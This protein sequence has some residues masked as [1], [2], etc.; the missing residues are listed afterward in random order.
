QQAFRAAF[1][2]ATGQ[3]YHPYGLALTAKECTTITAWWDEA[4]RTALARFQAR[5]EVEALDQMMACLPAWADR[6]YARWSRQGW[7]EPSA[8]EVMALVT[9]YLRVCDVCLGTV[10]EIASTAVA[11]APVVDPAQVTRDVE[12]HYSQEVQALRTQLSTLPLPKDTPKA[13]Q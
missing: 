5:G 12:Q 1:T 6:H 3:A 4:L 8:T 9:E 13:H 2:Q 11:H 10:A 7:R